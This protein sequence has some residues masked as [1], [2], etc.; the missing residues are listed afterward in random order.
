MAKKRTIYVCESCGYESPRWFGR[1]PSC[2]E[3]NTAKH[4]AIEPE[5][6][7]EFER[8]EP[9]P[10]I[11][12][13]DTETERIP[14]GFVE[15]DR[16]LGG[17]IV[18]GSVVL[19]GG[20]PGIGKST[21]MM[22]VSASLASKGNV[23]YVSGEESAAQLKS[24]AGRLKALRENLYLSPDP[25]VDRVMK[26]FSSPLLVVF[27]SLQTMRVSTTGTLP[28]SVSQ[29]R[30][31]VMKVMEMAKR[32]GVAIFLVGHV[33]KEGQIAGPKLV[34]H[35]VDVVIYFEGEQREELRVLRTVK[36]RFGPSGEVALFE[37]TD[38]GLKE[39][40]NPSAILPSELSGAP[41]VAFGVTV[42]GTRPI[43]IEI[44]ALVSK[45]Q[46]GAPRRTALGVDPARLTV[47]SAVLARHLKLPLEYRDI[48]VGVMGGLRITDPTTDLS[49]AGAILSSFFDI[50]LPPATSL[51]GE[52][53]L[54]GGVRASSSFSKR[55]KVAGSS[56]FKR[57]WG[58]EASDGAVGIELVRIDHVR[59]LGRLLTSLAR[60]G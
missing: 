56:G 35:L 46:F 4:L 19:I 51:I 43:C 13:P 47:L 15:L 10:I 24:R 39:I 37:M 42:E 3:W 31:S 58:P 25:T 59:E 14:T 29:V 26:N 17:G 32:K 5:K 57:V 41:G 54:D 55:L 44:Q 12:V 27:D 28:G 40:T 38:T 49:L 8:L 9:I 21:L 23:Y 16:I 50:P 45:T 22:Q 7:S 52:I 11:E 53:G 33:T 18:P 48:Y 60:E 1:C 36:N 2:G 20:E 6:G 30:D 34:E